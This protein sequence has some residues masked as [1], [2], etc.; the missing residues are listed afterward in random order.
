MSGVLEEIIDEIVKHDD[1]NPDHGV[2]CACHDKHARR[3]RQ[4]FREKRIGFN[5]KSRSNLMRVFGYITQ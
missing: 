1:E 3:L 4:L 5:N 2:G